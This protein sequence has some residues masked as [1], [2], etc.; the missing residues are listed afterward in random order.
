MENLFTSSK[1]SIKYNN[2]YNRYTLNKDGHWISLPISVF[3]L[4]LTMVK[5]Y[6]NDS[7]RLY[8]DYAPFMTI[9]IIRIYGNIEV[10]LKSEGA[11]SYMSNIRLEKSEV[12]EIVNNLIIIREK[13]V[14]IQKLGDMKGEIPIVKKN[15]KRTSRKKPVESVIGSQLP[16]TSTNPGSYQDILDELFMEDDNAQ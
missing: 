2:T 4:F 11:R 9:E 13:I 3:E 15:I 16:Q 8:C 6:E 12:D 7:L 5:N 14:K 1:V 10:K